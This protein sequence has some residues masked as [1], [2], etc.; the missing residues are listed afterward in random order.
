MSKYC[1][2]SNW[3]CT[4]DKEEMTTEWGDEMWSGSVCQCL[5]TSSVLSSMFPFIEILYI[6]PPPL[7]LSLLSSPHSFHHWQPVGGGCWAAE[8]WLAAG[9][10]G[11]RA[12]HQWQL[13]VAGASQWGHVKRRRIN[14]KSLISV[15]TITLQQHDSLDK[16]PALI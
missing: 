3:A 12:A 7:S 4:T 13:P 16:W 1:K 10:T 8:L 11:E 9:N 6:P 15:H 5:V 2:G 14:R